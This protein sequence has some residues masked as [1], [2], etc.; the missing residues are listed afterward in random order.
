M[1]GA[2]MMDAK[3]ALTEADGDFDAAGK[4]LRER[5][6]GKAAERADREAAQGAVGAARAGT[7]AAVVELKCETDFVAKSQDFVNLAE[8]LSQL[9]ADKGTDAVAERADVVD[10]LKITL[11]ENIQIG[12]VVRVVAGAGEVLDSYLHVQGGRGVNGVLVYLAIYLVMT[13][14]TFGCVLLMR[15]QGRYL[16]EISDLSGLSRRQ[17][18]LAAAIGVFMFSLAGIPPLAGF[19]GKLYVFLAAVD[20]GLTWLAVLGVLASCVGAYY[21]I[22]IVKVMYFDEPAEALDQAQHRAV[23]AISAVTAL[24]TVLFI[25]WPGPLLRAA[26]VAAAALAR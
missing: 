2:G 22:R 13:L 10:D 21:Y 19:F 24:A 3:R 7:V 1:T 12:R 4:W 11:K 15:R 23:G 20:A 26:G 9:V 16:E 18:M 25:A 14:G 8:E 17:P 6:L 5:G